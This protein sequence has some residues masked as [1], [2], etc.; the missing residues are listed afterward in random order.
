MFQDL[1]KKLKFQN[2]LNLLFRYQSPIQRI[3]LDQIID[4]SG[5][6]ATILKL[7]DNICLKRGILCH[8]NGYLIIVSNIGRIIKLRITEEKE[9][10]C[11]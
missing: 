7:T 3:N 10:L 1:Q 8:L 2:L 6:A 4:I 5:R 9:N 11:F